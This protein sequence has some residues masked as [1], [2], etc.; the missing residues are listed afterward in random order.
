M[1]FA[2]LLNSLHYE[3]RHDREDHLWEKRADT[4]TVQWIWDSPFG[5][6]ASGDGGMFWICGKPASGKSTLMEHIVRDKQLQASPRRT[7]NERWTVVHHFFFE[8][9]DSKDLR[10]NFEGFLRSLLYQFTKNLKAGN[11]PGDEPKHRWSLR[12]LQERLSHIL[13]QHSGPI[14]ILLDGL[15]EYQG[16]KWDLA[17]SLRNMANPRVKLYVTSR[18][19]LVFN[20]AFKQIPTIKMQ[21]WNGPAIDKMVTSRISRDMTAS[22]FYDYEEVVE[23]A[24]GIS[25]KA[26]GVFL[27]ARFAID[28]L[29]DGWSERLNLKQLQKR[30]EIIPEKL[31]DIYA[32]I[33]RKMKPE[34]RQQ[35]AYMLQLVL[36]AKRTLN[37]HE[38]Y[39]ATAHAAGRKEQLVKRL[40]ARDIRDFETRILAFTGGLHEVFPIRQLFSVQEMFVNVIHR[41]VRTYLESQDDKDSEN[42]RGWFQILGAAHDGTLHSH[43]LWLR[44]C[45]AIFPPSPKKIPPLFDRNNP[46]SFDNDSPSFDGYL[47]TNDDILPLLEY[48]ALYMLHHA[49]DVEQDLSINS[50]EAWRPSMT[51]SFLCHH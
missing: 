12:A 26:Q 33:F 1:R 14:C 7:I 35:A 49:A 27:W 4:E 34:R 29:R 25:K 41:S 13:N 42:S 43:M 50:Y 6:W 24:K 20:T 40:I 18:P 46:P 48:A 47:K 3:G 45:V 5:D 8:L 32:R 16:D 37:L 31:E 51:V 28:E 11:V 15:D 36:Y 21:E 2:A 44:V 17:S 38:F 19:N 30:L 39:V 10:N 9:N 22:G 23:L